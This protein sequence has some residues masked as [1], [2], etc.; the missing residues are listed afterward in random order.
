[1]AANCAEPANVVADITIG[2]KHAHPRRAREDA[3]GDPEP[4]DGDRERETGP[5]AV[6]MGARRFPAPSSMVTMLVGGG[7]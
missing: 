3:E 6:A 7:G 4:E 1:M 2:A 5:H